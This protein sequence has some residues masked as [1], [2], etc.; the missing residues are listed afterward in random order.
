MLATLKYSFLE[1]AFNFVGCHQDRLQQVHTNLLF[2][3][4]LYREFSW[5]MGLFLGTEQPAKQKTLRPELLLFNF[6]RCS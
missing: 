5:I 1:D 4:L 3:L 6:N 2:C